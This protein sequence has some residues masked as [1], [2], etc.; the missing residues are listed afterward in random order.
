MSKLTKADLEKIASVIGCDVNDIIVE[1]ELVSK[2]NGQLVD[3]E[4]QERLTRMLNR[5]V[6][7]VPTLFETMNEEDQETMFSMVNGMVIAE[8]SEFCN[9]LDQL[10]ERTGDKEM[11]ATNI[12]NALIADVLTI[13]CY[14]YTIT[15]EKK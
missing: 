8:I 1:D 15:I 5:D 7:K 10:Y 9:L 13:G 3:K 6:E 12:V 4:D 14:D 2:V 11:R